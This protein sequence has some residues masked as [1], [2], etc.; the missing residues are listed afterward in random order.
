M[1]E[2]KLK[3]LFV[4]L[5]NICRSPLAEAVFAHKVNNLGLSNK[6]ETDS[7]G[8]AAYHI[9]ASP[10]HRSIA[11]ANQHGIPI[12]HAG[13]QFETSDAEEFQYI[14]AMDQS[15]HRNIIHALSYK[16]E[17]LYLMRD[18]DPEGKGL[19][20]PDPYYGENDGFEKVYEML[21]RSI[22]EL[23]NHIRKHQ[24]I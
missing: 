24:D 1:S 16:P 23:I 15:N 12:T 19:D 2:K 10:D 21:D 17:G 18:F 22:D 5:G 6:I 7:C 3:V 14:L 8:T 4:C 11:V 9:G 20:V 13:R